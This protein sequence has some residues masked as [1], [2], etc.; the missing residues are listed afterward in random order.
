MNYTEHERAAYI[1]GDTRT[2]ELLG[3]LAELE[4]TAYALLG[5]LEV[6]GGDLDPGIVEAADKL[7]GVLQ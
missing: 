5:E 4:R 1:A 3:R 7:R 6:L 2:A